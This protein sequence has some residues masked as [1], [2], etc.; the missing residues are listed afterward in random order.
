MK[1]FLK[2]FAFCLVA[3]FGC[4]LLA[5][6]GFYGYYWSIVRSTPGEL[7]TDT[8]PGPIGSKVDPFIGTGGLPLVCP[9]TLGSDGTVRNG[10]ARPRHRLVV[11]KW[12]C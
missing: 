2:W 9:I 11:T 6:L 3:V 7:K 4:A 8:A 10:A 5:L 1:R 12:T